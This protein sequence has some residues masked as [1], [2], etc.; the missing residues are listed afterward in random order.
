M[1]P[2]TLAALIL[3]TAASALA[4]PPAILSVRQ[5]LPEGASPADRALPVGRYE[6][7]ELRV[8][9]QAAF[10]NPYDPDDVDVGAEFTA[11]S[12]RVWKIWA[13]YNPSSWSALWMVRFA[14][15][16]TGTWLYVLHARDREGSAEGKPGQFTVIESPAHGFVRIAANQRY[17]EYTDGVPF[18][19]VG[20]WYNDGYESLTAGSITEE[21]LDALKQHG[22]N[23]V[24]FY[25]SPLETMGTGL[26]RY[27]QSRAGRLDRIF[28][29]C[30][31][32]RMHISWNIWFH[33]YFSEEVWGGGSARYRTNPYRLVTTADRFFSSPEAWKYQEKLLRYV[34]ARWGCSRSLFLWFVVD[35]INGTEGWQNGG[36][37][38]AEQWCRRVHEWLKANDPYQRPTTGT[39]SG[40]IKQWW[41]GGYG[42]FDVAAREIYESQGHP[43][44]AG[45][46]A[47]PAADHP[48]QFS[49]RNYAKQTQDL[50]AGFRKPAIIRGMR[51]RSHVVR[52]GHARVPRDVPQRVV[53]GAGERL[54]RVTLLVVERADDR[55]FRPDAIAAVLFAVSARHRVR[56][57]PLEAGRAEG[58][59]RRR[60]GHGGRADDVRLGGESGRRSRQ[61]DV[62]GAGPRGRRL[63]CL[64]LPH[65]AR[66]VFGTDHGGIGRRRVG[67]HDSGVEDRPRACAADGRRRG[68]QD[69]EARRGPPISRETAPPEPFIRSIA[70]GVTATATEYNLNL[71]SGLGGCLS[72]VVL[73]HTSYQNLLDFVDWPGLQ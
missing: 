33:S 24:S 46:K 60:V 36:S 34:V 47:G 8:D 3:A 56:R 18:Y 26:G 48:L 11:P 57:K 55:R 14:P 38:A 10:E 5:A 19:P 63:R 62:H 17:F 13:F 37:E 2:H 22:A 29:W 69:R 58:V 66:A 25:S 40:G 21:G 73:P 54:E 70:G 23:F 52:A 64:P 71:Y 6:K 41:P 16:E 61:R 15:T 50:W 59:E 53:G 9:V 39:Q 68:I 45:G 65:M 35:E 31:K 49:Y 67:G 1:T 72:I 43:M 42:I 20:L 7:V 4:A 32:R 27:D 51:L 44:P 28:E 12:G 30:E